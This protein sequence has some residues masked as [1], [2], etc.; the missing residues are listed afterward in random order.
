MFGAFVIEYGHVASP[1]QPNFGA[2]RSDI[3]YEGRGVDC[4]VAACA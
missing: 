2:D 4:E 3:G 1:V